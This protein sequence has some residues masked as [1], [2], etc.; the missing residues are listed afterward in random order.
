M[1]LGNKPLA[2]GTTFDGGNFTM[3]NGEFILDANGNEILGFGTVASAVNY[4]KTTNSATGDPVIIGGGG[5]DTVVDVQ[6]ASNRTVNLSATT[7]IDKTVSGGT[8]SQLVANGLHNEFQNHAN[9]G[10]PVT[11]WMKNTAA[12]GTN[13][14][15]MNAYESCADVTDFTTPVGQIS[16]NAAGSFVIADL[17]DAKIKENVKE[18]VSGAAIVDALPA[19]GFNRIGCKRT[20]GWIAQDVQCLLP[21]SVHKGPKG[22]LMLAQSTLTPYLWDALRTTRKKQR[23]L[24]SRIKQLEAV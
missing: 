20:C 19:K 15:Y 23:R 3:E 16:H 18:D 11:N 9:K 1:N 4:L 14:V 13:N 8:F 5:D 2:A 17:S 10:N 24:E 22:H 12:A 6:L 21:D 7:S